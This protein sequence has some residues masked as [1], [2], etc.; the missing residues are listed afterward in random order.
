MSTK[1][2]SKISVNKAFDFLEMDGAIYE[3]FI[4]W[5]LKNEKYKKLLITKK[6]KDGKGFFITHIKDSKKSWKLL[7]KALSL[8]MNKYIDIDVFEPVKEKIEIKSEKG[9]VY[10]ARQLNEKSLYKIGCTNNLSKRL[11]TFKTGN[12]FVEMI[13][14]K[15]VDNRF[16][17]EKWF[18]NYFK[19]K[20]FKNEWYLL[21]QKDLENLLNIFNFNFHIGSNQV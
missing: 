19:K 6:S 1:K 4:T 8:F 14:S 18:H 2:S 15:C 7:S 11:G 16:Q 9:F 20:R 17:S 13:A 10:I 12:C 5:V 3:P 21:S